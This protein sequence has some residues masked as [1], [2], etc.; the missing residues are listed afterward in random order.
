MP[1][2]CQSGGNRVINHLPPPL[3][4]SLVI[5][6]PTGRPREL[7]LKGKGEF[8]TFE[9]SASLSN[10]VRMA[11]EGRGNFPLSHL[12]LSPFSINSLMRFYTHHYSDSSH[13]STLLALK[14]GVF[15]YLRLQPFYVQCSGNSRFDPIPIGW[16]V[17][18][19]LFL[20][21]RAH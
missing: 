21:L 8:S 13:Q 10:C 4:Q 7:L 18:P 14:I 11:R 15:F 16:S 2:K 9:N 17:G 20:S 3:L 12:F 1:S 19:S 6:R 5:G